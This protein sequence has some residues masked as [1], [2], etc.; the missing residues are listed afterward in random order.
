MSLTSVI[1]ATDSPPLRPRRALAGAGV[2][3]A[4]VLAKASS[5]PAFATA[6]EQRAVTRSASGSTVPSS[7]A[8]TITA[9]VTDR[10]ETPV[11]GALVTS[12]GPTETMIVLLKDGTVWSVDETA[13]VRAT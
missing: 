1:P 8:V 4:P 3:A 6:S 11:A 7:G 12:S 10:L 9:T 2:W 13:V 5:A